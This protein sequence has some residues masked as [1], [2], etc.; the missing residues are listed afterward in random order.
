MYYFK[1]RL[2][3]EIVIV[4]EKDRQCFDFIIESE[5]F[6]ACPFISFFRL[7][8]IKSSGAL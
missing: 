7:S 8:I 6:V 2:S 4:D 3:D 1:Q 5:T